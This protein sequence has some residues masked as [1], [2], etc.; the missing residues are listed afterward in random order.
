[1]VSVG[2]HV[3]LNGRTSA[4]NCAPV[5]SWR[6]VGRPAT[7]V[8]ALSGAD[9]PTPSFTP[10]VDGVYTVELAVSC[11]AGFGKGR[12]RISATRCTG[13]P[14]EGSASVP[15]PLLPGQSQA[16][17]G[18]GGAATYS[19]SLV[20]ATDATLSAATGQ[21]TIYSA[22]STPGADIVRMRDAYCGD[23][24]IPIA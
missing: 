6:F 24:D 23:V 20:G 1:A 7:S 11:G 12:G 9:T 8:A 13:K 4:V 17:Q 10:D 16:F 5:F 19:W 15:R 22:R 18:Y 21:S 2:T 3:S 14:L